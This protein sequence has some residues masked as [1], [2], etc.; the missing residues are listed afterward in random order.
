[1][2]NI[3]GLRKILVIYRSET[4]RIEYKLQM[5]EQCKKLCKKIFLMFSERRVVNKNT[6]QTI[7]NGKRCVAPH[8]HGAMGHNGGALLPDGQR[9]RERLL[10]AGRRD[11]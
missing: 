4:V 2:L 10:C 5:F 6:V 8:R 3:N 9:V 1:M 7:I 11:A